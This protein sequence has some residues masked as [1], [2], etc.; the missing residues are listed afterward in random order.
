[1]EAAGKESLLRDMQDAVTAVKKVVSMMK[2]VMPHADTADLQNKNGVWYTFLS[3]LD[4][5]AS[6][7]SASASD[8]TSPY[9]D[10]SCH[11]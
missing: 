9:L 7:A 6:I 1:M 11:I 5:R 10:M 3:L 4:S 2:K 8:R